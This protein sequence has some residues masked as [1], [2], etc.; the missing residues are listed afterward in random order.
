[1][2]RDSAAIRFGYAATARGQLHYAEAGEGPPL[3]LLHATPR[4]HRAFRHM[5]PLLA[6]HFRAVA[7]DTPGYGASHG[8]PEVFD[9]G[10]LADSLAQ[11]LDAL[12]LERAHVFGLH[13]GNKIGAAFAQ[14]W[15]DRIDRFVFAGQTHSIILDGPEREREIRAFCDRYFPQYAPSPD[16]SEYLRGWVAAH[17]ASQ[18][19]WWPQQLQ[20]GATVTAADVAMAETRV[21][22]H[23]QGWRSVVPTYRAIL[24]FDLP[25]ALRA[26]RAP[27]L[28][29]ELLSAN[30][31]HLERQA[32]RI[33]AIMPDAVPGRIEDAD[34]LTPERRPA[35]LVD[36]ITPFL[37]GHRRG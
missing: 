1:V 25:A 28:V 19:F 37:M 14:R 35:A 11:L 6:P 15:P 12:G 32:A 8:L 33:C 22:D 13:T 29:L 2:S 26:V 21:L 17:A 4:S 9:M 18:G 23:L 34:G 7:I 5:L 36:A 31:A 16:G 27:T 3:L 10:W 30:E 20:T 24:S